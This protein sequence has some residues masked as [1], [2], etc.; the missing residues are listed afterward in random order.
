MLSHDLVW[1]TPNL[2]PRRVPIHDWPFSI[3]RDPRNSLRV[4]NTA[5]GVSA[6]HVRIAAE[7]KAFRLEDVGSSNGTLVNGE[8]VTGPRTFRVGDRITLGRG[9]PSFRIEAIEVQTPSVPPVLPPSPH[10]AEPRHSPGQPPRM[11]ASPPPLP[12]AGPPP[13]PAGMQPK[14]PPLP[15][16]RA[17]PAPAPAPAPAGDADHK[18]AIGP[19]TLI[20][21]IDAASAAASRRTLVVVLGVLLL[22]AGATTGVWWGWFRQVDMEQFLRNCSSVWKVCSSHDDRLNSVGT[23]WTLDQGLLAT[24][25]HV[26]EQIQELRKA[27]PGIKIVARLVR[28]GEPVEVRIGEVLAHPDYTAF[29]EALARYQPRIDG[30]PLVPQGQFDVALL[31]VEPADHSMLGQPLRLAN[32]QQR[33]VVRGQ[34]L[35]YLGYPAE[36]KNVDPRHPDR[37]YLSGRCSRTTDCFF[38]DAKEFSGSGLVAVQF[39]SAGG[40]SGGP[41]FNDFGEV[42]GLLAAGDLA[43]VGEQRVSEGF[44]YGPHVDLLTELRTGRRSIRAAQFAVRF[45]EMYRQDVDSA[46]V[47]KEVQAMLS[48]GEP[49]WHLEAL[50]EHP[51]RD[52]FEVFAGKPFQLRLSCRQRV[53]AIAV[54]VDEPLPLEL[55]S[56][57]RDITSQPRPNIALLWI[58]PTDKAVRIQLGA[59]ER[60]GRVRLLLRKM[61][62]D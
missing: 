38:G 21:H 51:D 9:G 6:F 2:Q 49:R 46:R 7:G 52:P 42:V 3:G 27:K 48:E 55:T 26:A 34:V 40:A 43:M 23:A 59:G 47:L 28:D 50:P 60:S 11:P 16:P 17:S 19:N 44:V 12:P 22:L 53:L 39:P 4:P 31:E 30:S 8:E 62:Q 54:A 5:A 29:Q 18:P 15:T 35:H 1:E 14:L 41:I 58:E 61:V 56:D 13:L 33:P 24:N 45:Q 37:W 10:G 25:A 20:R 57:A 36:N 32:S